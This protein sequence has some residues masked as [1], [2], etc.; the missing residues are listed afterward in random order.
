ML[1]AWWLFLIIPVSAFLGYIACGILM[2]GSA[3]DESDIDD[4]T[5]N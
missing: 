3:A 1:S 5:G 2:V 4:S